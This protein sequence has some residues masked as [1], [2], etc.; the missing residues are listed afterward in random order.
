MSSPPTGSDSTASRVVIAS[1]HASL[2][3]ETLTF[4]GS[5]A[6]CAYSQIRPPMGQWRRQTVAVVVMFLF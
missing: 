3:S 5:S 1:P 2:L 4:S 6:R